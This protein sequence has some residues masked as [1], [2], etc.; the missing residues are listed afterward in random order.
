MFLFVAAQLAWSNTTNDW[1]RMFIRCSGIA[2]AVVLMFMETGFRNALF[3]SNVR[4]MQEKIIADIVI[5]S[6]SRYMFSSRQLISFDDLIAAR[7]CAGV[8]SAEPLYLENA[9]SEIR[10]AGCVSRRVR[11]LAFDPAAPAFVKFGL[12]DIADRLSETDNAAAD[13]YSKSFFQFPRDAAELAEGR[14]YELAGKRVNIVGLFKNG[15]DFSNEGNLVM[16]PAN[17]G[18][19]FPMRG[20]GSPLSVVDYVVVRCQPDVDKKQVEAGLKKLLGPDLIVQSRESFVMSERNFWSSNTPIGLVFWVGT[21]I[22]FVVGMSICYQVLATDILDHMGEFSTLKAMG[23][24]PG[25]FALVVISQA[26]LLSL[27]SFLPGIV[28]AL[29]LFKVTNIGTGLFLFL[30]LQRAAL[31]LGLTILM[32]VLSGLIALRRL[33]LADPASLF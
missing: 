11:V 17:F 16:T 32:C 33:L 25:F 30:N 2:I 21:L 15:I 22:G 7:S 18:R 24:P 29:L 12:A 10:C 31:V 3:D 28:I 5:R 13:T 23:Y 14:Y 6:E 8:L 19:Y 26:F 20:N 4:V 9:V 1:K 27:V